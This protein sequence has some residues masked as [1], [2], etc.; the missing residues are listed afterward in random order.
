MSN[1]EQFNAKLSH[2]ATL[3]V[4]VRDMQERMDRTTDFETWNTLARQLG[5]VIETMR[6]HENTLDIMEALGNQMAVMKQ[7][8][9]R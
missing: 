9:V 3:R 5:A 1:H 6:I 2:V 4:I 8:V 7:E